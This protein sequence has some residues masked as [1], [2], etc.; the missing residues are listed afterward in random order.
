MRLIFL[1]ATYCNSDSP[2][3][4]VINGGAIFLCI[5]SFKFSSLATSNCFKM[6]CATLLHSRDN[7]Q[8]PAQ[9]T[10][11]PSIWWRCPGESAKC[12]IKTASSDPGQDLEPG[13]H[14]W[15]KSSPCKVHSSRDLS[16]PVL[17]I[18]E[19][20]SRCADI[21][22]DRREDHRTVGMLQSGCYTF[23]DALSLF[24][25]RGRIRGKRV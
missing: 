4:K 23:N 10:T 6:T 17:I 11:G 13:Q 15:Y 20:I 25:V 2:P 24:G 8:T 7:K 18:Q 14:C 1:S 19:S 22:L 9:I 16:C 21:H 12:N 5:D 3:S